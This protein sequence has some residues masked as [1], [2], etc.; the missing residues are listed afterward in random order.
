MI[1]RIREL[2]ENPDIP[3]KT[4]APMIEAL[5]N[6]HR[7]LSTRQYVEDHLDAAERHMDTHA[8][9]QRVAGNLGVPI[10]KV[11]DHLG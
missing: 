4:R 3:A 9:L 11:S 2:T 5:D 8:S 6:Q 10:V 1:P 7:D